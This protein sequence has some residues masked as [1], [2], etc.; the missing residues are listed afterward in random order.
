MNDFLPVGFLDFPIALGTANFGAEINEEI[1]FELLDEFVRLG[2]RIID[3]ALIY[4]AWHESGEGASEKV[5]GRYFSSY[6]N[7]SKLFVCTKGAHPPLDSISE[8]RLSYDAI[9]CDI[10]RSLSHLHTDYIDVYFLHRDDERIPTSDV[11]STLEK[12]KSQFKIT[13]FGLSNWKH[14]RIKEV[15]SINSSITVIS[16][17]GLS[18]ASYLKVPPLN[19][20]YMTKEE[21]A[22]YEEYKLPVMAFNS[23][24]QG[25]FREGLLS[26]PSLVGEEKKQ[27]LMGK[28]GSEE[29][30]EKYRRLEDIS[31][32]HNASINA[33]ALAALRGRIYPVIPIAGAKT[34]EQIKDSLSAMGLSLTPQEIDF[35]YNGF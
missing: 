19:M 14:N 18:F 21:E 5:L 7:R 29:N 9:C 2:G 28:Y 26:E 15:L 31:K 6:S 3:T 32:K 1:A 10:E 4:G 25:F 23:Q 24:A 27:Q 11:I 16:Q 17:I 35:L 13:S 30:I 34:K 12:V 20:V 22:F 33:T 8:S